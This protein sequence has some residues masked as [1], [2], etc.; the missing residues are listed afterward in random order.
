LRKGDRGGLDVRVTTYPICE[1]LAIL[2]LEHARPEQLDATRFAYCVWDFWLP[3]VLARAAIAGS[4]GFGRM[5]RFVVEHAEVKKGGD[6]TMKHVTEE[7]I[8]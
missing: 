8:A 1:L 4:L 6:R 2:G 5:R 3:P 7:L